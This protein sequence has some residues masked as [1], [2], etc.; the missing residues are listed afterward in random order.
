[1]SATSDK[2]SENVN[3]AIKAE[4]RHELINDT[5]IAAISSTGSYDE[6]KALVV[7]AHLKP[8]N[9][10]KAPLSQLAQK[11]SNGEDGRLKPVTQGFTSN[12]EL[13]SRE[14]ASVLSASLLLADV[15]KPTSAFEFERDWARHC[16]TAEHKLA[17][18]RL[19][20]GEELPGLFG[21]QFGL[22]LLGQFVTVFGTQLPKCAAHEEEGVEDE[23]VQHG[24]YT[25]TLAAAHAFQ[26]LKYLID[27]QDFD[28]NVS[29]LSSAEQSHAAK[30][31]A[32][33]PH[34]PR[35]LLLLP[36][37]ALVTTPSLLPRFL[38][39]L[40]RVLYPNKKSHTLCL[41]PVGTLQC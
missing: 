7:G 5:K 26:V 12:Q 35:L 21:S 34:N 19:L 4:Q 24:K 18:L 6:F 17:Y 28:M 39:L 16:K 30:V 41:F 1:M 3:R 20:S 10:Q 27:V 13:R 11:R 36:L 40:L 33:L 15:G 9:L 29:F 8:V 31:F 14:Q 38:L 37:L 25:L 22:E 23:E 32:H 2:L